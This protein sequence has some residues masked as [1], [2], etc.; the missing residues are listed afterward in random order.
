MRKY[1]GA[2]AFSFK[3]FYEMQ[4]KCVVPVL[5]LR[6]SV[7]REP[8]EF[9]VHWIKAVGPRLG[10]KGRIGNCIVECL[11]PSVGIL[12]LRTRKG[13]PLLYV[14]YFIAVE[15]HVHLG[16]GDRGNILLLAV[17][18]NAASRLVRRL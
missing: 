3:R 4:Q 9:I 13:V 12:V 6:L 11:K 7:S 5:C 14:G 18:G 1:D 17:D 15:N 16:Q 8:V 10:G 2:L